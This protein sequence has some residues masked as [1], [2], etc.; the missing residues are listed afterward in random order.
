MEQACR[1]TFGQAWA[2]QEFSQRGPGKGFRPKH[3]LVIQAKPRTSFYVSG[4]SVP[5]LVEPHP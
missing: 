5:R 3:P 1:P 2:G 4:Q